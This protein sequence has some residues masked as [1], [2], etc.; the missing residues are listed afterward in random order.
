MLLDE[1]RDSDRIIFD[2]KQDL[3]WRETMISAWG[4]T[5]SLGRYLSIT[6]ML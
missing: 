5:V 2:F 3:L 6:T 1:Y 4:P